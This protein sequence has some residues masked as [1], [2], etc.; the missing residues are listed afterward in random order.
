MSNE[1]FKS[2][3]QAYRTLSWI[4]EGMTVIDR[5]NRKIGKVK[6]VQF[7]DGVDEPAFEMPSEFRHLPREVQTRLMRD[8]FIQIDAGLF[9]RDRFATPDQIAGMTDEGLRL[10][11]VEDRLVKG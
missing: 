2:D 7:T 10:T 8:G 4:R 5:E 3:S 1:L 9:A 6:Y 11:V